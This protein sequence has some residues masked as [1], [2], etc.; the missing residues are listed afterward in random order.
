MKETRAEATSFHT[1]ANSLLFLVQKRSK[2]RQA[3]L[4]EIYSNVKITKKWN[5]RASIAPWIPYA[6]W[7][8]LPVSLKNRKFKRTSSAKCGK[9]N[10]RGVA[11]RRLFRRLFQITTNA[12]YL[13]NP[14]K[15]ASVFPDSSQ[16]IRLLL[17]K[18]AATIRTAMADANT[19]CK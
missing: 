13:T 15:V 17:Q 14:T 6:F 3:D 16:R 12:C 4:T 18:N 11:I 8:A 9:G 2:N 19:R 10:K 5:V 7:D 1:F